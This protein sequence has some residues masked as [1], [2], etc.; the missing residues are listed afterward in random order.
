MGNIRKEIKEDTLENLE[1]RG[2]EGEERHGDEFPVE[3]GSLPGVRYGIIQC[4]INEEK[5]IWP[6]MPNYRAGT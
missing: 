6:K 3:Y 1:E 4:G 5:E 2:R